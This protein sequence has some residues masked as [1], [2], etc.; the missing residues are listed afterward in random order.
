MAIH[1][2][3]RRLTNNDEAHDDRLLGTLVV[4]EGLLTQPLDKNQGIASSLTHMFKVIAKTV[5]GHTGRA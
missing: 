3:S 4:E 1:D 2:F 5:I